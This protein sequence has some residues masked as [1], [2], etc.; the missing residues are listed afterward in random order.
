M[1]KNRQKRRVGVGLGKHCHDPHLGDP[2]CCDLRFDTLFSGQVVAL[3]ASSLLASVKHGVHLLKP[4]AWK[5]VL[6]AVMVGVV[7]G[8]IN[9]L[10]AG[11]PLASA[12]PSLKAFVFALNP[13]IFE[14]VAFR[15]FL[16]ALSIYLL[17]GQITTKKERIWVYVLLVVPHALVH[18]PDQCFIDGRLRIDLGVLIINPAYHVLVFGLPFALLTLKR[19]LTSAM[20]AH[21]LVDFIRFVVLGLPW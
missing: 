13:G 17:G 8:I 3:V 1:P 19:D 14:E 4:P 16:Y 15:L 20:I 5:S 12:K 21:G 10:P 7:L 11:L 18:V 6:A 9:L 2:L